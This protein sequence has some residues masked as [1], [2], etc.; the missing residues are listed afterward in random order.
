[1]KFSRGLLESNVSGYNSKE[2]TKKYPTMQQKVPL[3]NHFNAKK[4][5]IKC[6]MEGVDDMVSK[7]HKY[8]I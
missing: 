6:D 2:N 5:E 1:M 3:I 7:N 4:D 8:I